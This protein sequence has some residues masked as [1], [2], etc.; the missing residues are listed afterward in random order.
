MKVIRTALPR[1]SERSTGC[2]SE[3][4]SRSG[5]AVW[6]GVASP[7]SYLPLGVADATVVEDPPPQP[8]RSAIGAMHRSAIRARQAVLI[9]TLVIYRVGRVCSLQHIGYAGVLP[10]VHRIRIPDPGKLGTESI[11]P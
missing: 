1:Y 6:G 2:P 7:P 5:G 4:R 9:R 3:S 11:G 10:R 8:V